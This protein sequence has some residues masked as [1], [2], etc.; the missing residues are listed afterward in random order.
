MSPD[1]SGLGAYI[2]SDKST[3]NRL[4][5]ELGLPVPNHRV[6]MR[7]EQVQAAINALGFPLV[8][9]PV[10]GKKGRGVSV[11]LENTEAVLAAFRGARKYGSEVLVEELIDGRQR[12]RRGVQQVLLGYLEFHVAEGKAELLGGA[13]RE[14]GQR[15]VNGQLPGRNVDADVL[16]G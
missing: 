3:T 4:L 2:A 7:E 9:K 15:R 12:Q 14:S 13:L 8:V 5:F 16:H 1:T 11:G 10:N 6:V